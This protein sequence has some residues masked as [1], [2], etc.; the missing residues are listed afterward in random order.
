MYNTKKINE[1]LIWIGAN[2][3]RLALFENIYPIERG[4]SYNSYI[5][6]DEK[7]VLIDTVDKAVSMQFFENLEYELKESK[8][9]YLI[10]QHMEPDHAATLEE[11][12]NRH[13][14]A[15]IVCNQKTQT[16]IKQ[17]FD[18]N[19][20]EKTYLV[21]EGDTLDIGR[22][23]LTFISA[24]MVHWP[25]V[26]VTYDTT[27]KILFS[28]DAFGTFGALSG[29]IY[30]DEVNF[31]GE[32]LDEA[33][34]YYTNIVGKYGTQ[35]QALLKKASGVQ[36]NTIC[37]LH[38]PVWRKN[39]SWIIDKYQKW[40]TYTPEINSVL[41][42]SGSIYGHTEN[43]A[44]ILAAKLAD[45]GIKEIK[46]YD[47][48]KIHPSVIV[49]E[50]FKYSHI[51]VASSTYNAGIFSP[52]ETVLADIKAHNLQNR[53]IG[54]MY[55]GSWAPISEEVIKNI[56]LS[57][58]NT[59][60]LN[61]TV[62]ITSAVKADTIK[63]ID[64]LAEEIYETLP[65]EKLDTNALFKINY[66][67]YLL[68]AKDGEKDNACIINAVNQISDN[69]KRIAIS[70]NKSNLTHNM[71]LKNK[72][73]CISV[74]TED[75]P[76]SVFEKYGY[77]S[78]NNTEKFGDKKGIKR[79]ANGLAYLPE[80][81]NAV[82]CAKVVEIEDFGTH[83]LFT[84]EIDSAEVLS[85]TASVTYD[86]YLKN[87]K[88]APKISEKKVEGYVCKICGYVYEGTE[89]PEDFICPICKHGVQDFEKI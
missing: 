25:E 30:A 10:V 84:G 81:A 77:H 41:I 65:K 75:T 89:I 57:L 7:T 8:L 73:F 14:E 48:S 32:W 76:F 56:L 40:S 72:T 55:N 23:K 64:L 19:I 67:L 88:P 33:R 80:Y 49:S 39:I 13:P 70:V 26:M 27:D 31:E 46:I 45:K 15:K 34:R 36:I 17:F 62:K 79:C 60:I 16:M 42:L 53:T 2:D 18:F 58:K 29:N 6:K 87:I 22:H 44:E 51:I 20:E 38:G 5:L 47:V 63:A 69:P 82:I 83:T 21:K 35:V 9:D 1:D 12:V 59:K 78:G 50:A 74:L 43:A 61:T 11:L 52:M 86:Y 71:I 24:P 4:V 28:A 3:R 37:P 68:S 85:N 54:I 66:G